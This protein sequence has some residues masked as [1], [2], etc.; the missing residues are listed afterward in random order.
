MKTFFLSLVPFFSKLKLIRVPVYFYI[1]L[2][3][4]VLDTLKKGE[5]YYQK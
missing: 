4:S 5:G 1:S 3:F 2:F